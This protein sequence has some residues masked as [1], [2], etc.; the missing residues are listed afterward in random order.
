MPRHCFIALAFLAGVNASVAAPA[1]GPE[2]QPYVAMAAP[3]IVL[4]HV[5]V[6]DGTGNAARAEQTIVLRDGRIAA[7]GPAGGVT[8]PAGAEVHVPFGGIKDSG[9]GPHEQGRSAIEFYTEV[10]TIYVDP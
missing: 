7:I 2:V 6:I 5:T 10:V 4:R 8:E 9:Y 1:L 3:V